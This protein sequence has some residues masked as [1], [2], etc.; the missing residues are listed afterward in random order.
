[1]EHALGLWASDTVLDLPLPPAGQLPPHWLCPE[2]VWAGE[3][4]GRFPLTLSAP[5]G[6]G[7]QGCISLTVSDLPQPP[8]PT[9]YTFIAPT[10]TGAQPLGTVIP[11]AHWWQ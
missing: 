7:G 8:G 4:L 11:P 3:R 5:A 1:M 2:G 10:S 9:R 6:L